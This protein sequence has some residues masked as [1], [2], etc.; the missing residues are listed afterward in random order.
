MPNRPSNLTENSNA[1]DQDGIHSGSQ[2]AL[3]GDGNAEIKTRT[4][5]L[6][7]IDWS[8][9]N[10]LKIIIGVLLFIML[11]LV[12]I[13]GIKDTELRG[14]SNRYE[15]MEAERDALI[16]EQKDAEANYEALMSSSGE[17]GKIYN[18]AATIKGA[19]YDLDGS[20]AN[21]MK[22]YDTIPDFA[23]KY[24]DDKGVSGR[25]LK[26][27]MNKEKTGGPFHKPLQYKP[28]GQML[29]IKVPDIRADMEKRKLDVLGFY[30]LKK[31][32]L[33]EESITVF[34]DAELLLIAPPHWSSEKQIEAAR[35]LKALEEDP[36]SIKCCMI[37]EET[38]DP[39]AKKFHINEYLY[40]YVRL[41]QYMDIG[42]R[43]ADWIYEGQL[44][45]GYN[46]WTGYGR[47]M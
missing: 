1:E 39:G 8:I 24:G 27:Y 45:G 28:E 12:I 41:V 37:Y 46:Q 29:T 42:A 40:G 5:L 31:M 2:D 6:E 17:Y 22:V 14:L 26:V 33:D 13:V 23:K 43:Y 21:M 32:Q 19:L 47:W 38:S 34:F 16:K 18:Y 15:A 30:Q 10:P 36:H 9:K 44:A 11:I 7:A 20:I 4:K 35:K 25:L 3:I